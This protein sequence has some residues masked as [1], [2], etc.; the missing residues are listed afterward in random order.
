MDVLTYG[1]AE[2]PVR[3]YHLIYQDGELPL[4]RA[5]RLSQIV[6][7]G[8]AGNNSESLPPLEFGY[9]QFQPEARKFMALAGSWPANS[10]PHKNLAPVTLFD[11]DLPHILAL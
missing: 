3:T 4:N 1:G 6:L 11:L 7:E 10:L 9:T 5:S 2:I 8:H